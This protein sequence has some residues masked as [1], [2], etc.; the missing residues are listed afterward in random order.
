VWRFDDAHVVHVCF[1][2]CVWC[3]AVGV[4]KVNADCAVIETPKGESTEAAN[5]GSYVF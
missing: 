5:F 3:V 4:S 2:R 1:G